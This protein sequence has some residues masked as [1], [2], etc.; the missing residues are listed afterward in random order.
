MNRHKE[1]VQQHN[2]ES[3]GGKSYKDVDE[4][5]SIVGGSTKQ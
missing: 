1:K 4:F 5:L 2:T 3:G